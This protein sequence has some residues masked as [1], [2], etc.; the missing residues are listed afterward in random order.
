MW[1]AWNVKT[2]E[3]NLRWQQREQERENNWKNPSLLQQRGREPI[4]IPG[5]QNLIS[6]E[7]IQV[8]AL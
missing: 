6:P 8:N 4:K 2:I 7:A 5:G 3:N 1:V